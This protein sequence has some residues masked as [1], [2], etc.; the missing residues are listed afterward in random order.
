M[1]KSVQGGWL[2]LLLSLSHQLLTIT[3]NVKYES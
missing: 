3:K 2:H 1:F